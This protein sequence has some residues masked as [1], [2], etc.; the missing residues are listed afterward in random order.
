MKTLTFFKLK[1]PLGKWESVLSC[2]LYSLWQLPQ[3]GFVYGLAL[4]KKLR[5][6]IVHVSKAAHAGLV[7][8]MMAA[9]ANRRIYVGLGLMFVAA[10]LSYCWYAL[11][12]GAPRIH[13]WYHVN[14]FHLFFLI[15]FQLAFSVF[16]IGLYHYLPQDKRT[17]LLSIP[18][19]FLFMSIV[20]NI[21]AKSNDD[22][23]RIGSLSLWAAGV[24]LSL[25]LFF[26]LDYLVWRK[27]HRADAF[28]KR[29]DGIVEIAND[30]PADK[31]VSMFT[32]TWRERKEFK[33]KA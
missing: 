20:V 7:A 31:V 26:G 1:K 18:L 16:F 14:Y 28:E 4:M 27:F 2:L 3:P 13:G 8:L 12:E 22:I 32:T 21:I 9:T 5:L 6:W 15:R 19:G 10:P 23:H 24:C 29:L 30:L 25:V 11:F 33:A 17:K